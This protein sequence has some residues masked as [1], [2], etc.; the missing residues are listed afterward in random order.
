MMPSGAN[1]KK[2]TRGPRGPKGATGPAG[3]A[4]PAGVNGT[5]GPPGLQGLPGPLGG[6]P[7]VPRVIPISTVTDSNAC[8][9][10]FGTGSDTA[11]F[12]LLNKTMGQREKY[13]VCVTIV[14][15][16]TFDSTYSAMPYNLLT[17]L[18]CGIANTSSNVPG[19]NTPSTSVELKDG[20]NSIAMSIVAEIDTTAVQQSDYNYAVLGFSSIAI[21]QNI[22]NTPFLKDIALTGT[23]SIYTY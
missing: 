13:T 17:V 23:V 9:F 8:S 21:Q 5:N 20:V 15:V 19:P 7:L 10:L 2:V 1:A 16:C 18:T 6:L 22:Y 3:P 12:I 14:G 4:G 11:A